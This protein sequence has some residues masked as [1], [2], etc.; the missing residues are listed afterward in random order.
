V[1][2][3]FTSALVSMCIVTGF[4]WSATPS[5]AALVHPRNTRL[6]VGSALPVGATLVSAS[7]R[8]VARVVSGG[9]I[10][11]THDRDS[12]W[13]SNAGSGFDRVIRTER[14][15]AIKV[16]AA[17]VK[18]SSPSAP[19][20][21][22]VQ[23]SGDLALYSRGGA[24]IWQGGPV[25]H[26]TSSSIAPYSRTSLFG[27][28]NPSLTCFTCQA[29]TITGSAPPS[30]TL[31][32]GTDIDAMTG[33][34][35]TV[36]TLFSAPAIG[37]DLG[38]TLS[39]DAQLAQSE[40]T[41]GS[42][43]TPGAFGV[44][45]NSTFSASINQ[46]SGSAP[47]ST[48][49]V[50]QAN[51]SQV[52]FNQSL[53]YGT[54]TSCQPVNVPTDGDYPTTNKYTLSGSDLQ[55]CS[56]ASV[57]G[58][59][60][61]NDGTGVTYQYD[62][63]QSVDDFAWNGQLTASTSA[64]AQL[65]SSPASL[66]VLYD[67]AGGSVA[68]TAAGVTLPEQCPSGVTQCTIVYSSDARD[69]VEELNSSGLV[70]TI[71]DPSGATYSLTY[72]S[73]HDLTSVAVPN[74]TG[75]PSTWNYAYTTSAGS[76]YTS[77][78]TKIEDPDYNA[79]LSTVA[80]STVVNYYA[81]TS[82]TP[83][84][85]SSLVDATGATTSY[86]YTANCA[87]SATP[88]CSAS[89]QSQATTITYPAEPLCPTPTSGCGTGSPVEID[90]YNSGLEISSE[91]GAGSSN[92]LENETWNYAWN[93]GNGVANTSEIVTYPDTLNVAANSSFVAPSATIITDPSGN[94]VAT[95]NALGDQAT[96][97]Y[98]D[99]G[100]ND[101]NEL[102]W[103]YPG[104]SS[105][106][107]SSPP[108]GSYVYT[109]NSVGQV[110]TST[111]PLGN[112]TSYGYY[113]NYSL[114]CFAVPPS[115]NGSL[116]APAP[117][118]CTSS[119][120]SV[121][122]GAIG[123]PVGATTY[124]YDAQGDVVASTIDTND[125]SANADSQTTTADYDVM[126]NVLWSI[127]ATGQSLS[128][129]SSN[130]FATVTTYS[131]ADLPVSVT[132]PGEGTTTYTYDPAFNIVTT[133]TPAATTNDVY[134]GDNRL[135]YQLVA[136]SAVSGLTCSSSAQAGSSAA[137]YVT[138]SVDVASTTDANGN[139]T[140]D[141]YGDL[142]YPNSPTEVVD[143]LGTQRSYDA[144]NDYG[145]SCVSGGVAPVDAP[146]ASETSAQCSTLAGDTSNVVNPLGSATAVTDPSGNLTTNAYADAAYPT[147]ITSTTNALGAT[148]SYTYDADGHLLTTTNPDGTAISEAYDPNSEVCSKEPTSFAY[149]CGEGPSAAGVTLYAY[150]DAGERASMSDQVADPAT[151]AQ[152]SAITTY[153]YTAGQLTSTTDSNGATVSYLYNDTGQV[154]CTAYPVSVGASCGTLSS[155]ASAS[156]SNTIV[157]NTYD[158]DGRLHSVSDWLGNT[159][160]YGYGD[161]NDPSAPTTVN[162]PSGTGLSATYAHDNAGNVTSL[163]AGSSIS[164]AWTYNADEQVTTTA[165]SGVTSSAT[166]YNANHQ[167]T[168]AAN[169]STSTSNDT[170]NLAA[171][172]EII[173]DAPPSG[174]AANF[175][176]NAGDELCA[177]ATSATACGSSPATG[178]SYTYT[179]NGQRATASSFSG[180]SAGATTYDA[181]NT[182]GE[183]CNVASAA[184]PCGS[185][186]TSGVSYTYNGDGLR[187]SSTTSTSTTNYA[188]DNVAGGSIPL[189]INDATTA[190]GS[191]TNVSYLYGDLLF[192]GTAPIE[193]IT[194]TSSGTSISYLVSNQTGVQGVYNGSGGSLGAV[195]EMSLY[196]LYGVQ[197]ISTGS[198][199]TPFGFQGAYQDPTSL[200]YLIN[201]YYDP[202][203]DQFLSVDPDVVTTDQPYVFT[204]DDPLNATD[205]LGLKKGD[206]LKVKVCIGLACVS[207]VL[208]AGGII[209]K[210]SKNPDAEAGI[211][212]VERGI[213]EIN[214][215]P[216]PSGQTYKPKS[217]NNLIPDGPSSN[218]VVGAVRKGG[219]FAGL[220]GGIV[221]F[222]RGLFV[223][224][225]DVAASS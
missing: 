219:I 78:L 24:P 214:Y 141:Y 87:P 25:A 83:G 102:V 56:L 186:P 41:S 45:W 85:V 16:R 161:A 71:I 221:I 1:K 116:S 31:D 117:T 139:T 75:T 58:Q 199:V 224:S 81:S 40:L 125:T 158:S 179:T 4:A 30:N 34:F 10:D 193:Q 172:G 19:S 196:S 5:G 80:H 72:D 115:V 210:P 77:D 208:G 67:V 97:A 7:G 90:E 154:A 212:N 119:S 52:S 168:A 188:W 89:G 140:S 42:G 53:D 95:T 195:E 123:S 187:T 216:A 110:L 14:N 157:D 181:W 65:G 180:G 173:A 147:A 74:G 88:A 107:A 129:S 55:W 114:P 70:T 48:I 91:L 163:V 124:S 122:A 201:R 20:Y 145:T 68:K 131:S 153:A 190:G 59:I 50:D 109:Y 206:S 222:G 69:L 47:T 8:F 165:I 143:A 149:P 220:V 192:G 103:S 151:P 96:S 135:C 217:S 152:W 101:L 166:T 113:A 138:G 223:F 144:Y 111:D 130:P 209:S 160:T 127:P 207:T 176:Y 92:A 39:Y 156:T 38:L 185:V 215:G 33:D 218:A 126:G 137:T 198:A 51:G 2:R 200:L 79:S 128:Q 155:P 162:Y 202:S 178:V 63:A 11:I 189:D 57:Q 26:V 61:D 174:P 86:T 13:M 159:T 148:T 28:S 225:Q 112:V 29:A 203:T 73:A 191:T 167:I 27:N 134:D 194:T 133:A 213:P 64:A 98:N 22:A 60:S 18:P 211:P 35:S 99:V 66:S 146:P 164:D 17:A 182:Y 175:S 183:L 37:G 12:V 82:G 136:G 106:G 105:N 3:V 197:T 205:P 93:F 84:M 32:S 76:P 104:P 132:P 171:N 177:R 94:I 121:D 15:G 108:P 118:G 21:L 46:Q 36:N 184:T 142:A 62:D 120:S 9:R 49:T 54:S 204:N 169:L 150:N 44:G 6:Y 43:V 23:N 100:G 170:Y